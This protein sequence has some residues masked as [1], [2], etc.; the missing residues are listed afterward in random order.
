MLY[1]S[2]RDRSDLEKS[3]LTDEQMILTGHFSA[4]EETAER[5]VGMKLKGLVFSYTD[6]NGKPYPRSNGKPFHRIKPD[7]GEGKSDRPKYLS[8][9]GEGCRPYFSKLYTD[10]KNAITSTK[11]ELWETE[12]EKKGDCGCANGLAVIAFGGVDGWV[13]SRDRQ[14]ENDKSKS[15]LELKVIDY[16]NRR[17]NL[18]FDSDIIEK[19]QVQLALAKRAIALKTLGAI[20]YLVL[21]PNEIDGSKNGLDDFIFRHGVVALQTLAHEALKVETKEA[22]DE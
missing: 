6:P 5:L 14:D 17:V 16:K 9:K 3:G 2:E 11:I 21:L 20:P 13:D 18:C 1:L 22:K 19:P 12:G 7:Y 15:L 10:W 4:D 8:P